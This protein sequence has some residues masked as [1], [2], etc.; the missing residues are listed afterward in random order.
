MLKVRSMSSRGTAPARSSHWK[1]GG[2]SHDPDPPPVDQPLPRHGSDD[3]AGD[4]VLAVRVEPR[5]LGRLTAEERAPV[6][7]ARASESV[8]H[9]DGDI[10][11]EPAGRQ[12]IEE[13]EGLRPL[14]ED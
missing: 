12:I 11:V 5:H 13:E 4:V 8:H 3:E 1:S 10:G 2:T 14:Y 9:L 6:L 7:T